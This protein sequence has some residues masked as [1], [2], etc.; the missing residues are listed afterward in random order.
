MAGKSTFAIWPTLR[1]TSHCASPDTDCPKIKHYKDKKDIIHAAL[2]INI[3]RIPS[4]ISSCFKKS[5]GNKKIHCLDL[6]FMIQNPNEISNINIFIPEGLT[7]NTDNRGITDLSPRVKK[8]ETLCALFNDDLSIKQS[9]A[10][11]Q[12]AVTYDNATNNINEFILH[13]L[14]ENDIEIIDEF[15]GSIIKLSTPLTDKNKPLY[16]RIRL[17]ESS[18]KHCTTQEPLANDLLQKAFTKIEVTDLQINEYRTLNKRLRD[19][20][21]DEGSFL[22]SKINAFYICKSD[23]NLTVFSPQYSSCR[24]LEKDVWKHYIDSEYLYSSSSNGV[25]AYHWK[26]SPKEENTGIQ[27]CSIMVK[28]QTES[29]SWPRLIKYFIVFFTISVIIGAT[30]NLLYKVLADQFAPPTKQEELGQPKQPQKKGALQQ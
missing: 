29:T 3:W 11:Y 16:I 4:S 30:G 13:E 1:K 17:D 25:L 6:G 7:K 18:L 24:F 2:H 9:F 26:F 12:H 27:N 23:N 20:I 14:T 22:F 10:A 5:K 15:D 8:I 19:I 21:K 28:S